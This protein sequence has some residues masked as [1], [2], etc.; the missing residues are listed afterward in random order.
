MKG[1]V[2]PVISAHLG[3]TT[4]AAAC[5]IGVSCNPNEDEECA[6]P[7]AKGIVGRSSSGNQAFGSNRAP[8]QAKEASVVVPSE[9]SCP[10]AGN[11][12]AQSKAADGGDG[13]VE[14]EHEAEAQAIAEGAIRQLK[15][16]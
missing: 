7:N 16:Y 1:S 2:S 10:A 6:N 9:V 4:S 13:K 8:A 11:T 15:I 14:A 5:G 3:C 12:T